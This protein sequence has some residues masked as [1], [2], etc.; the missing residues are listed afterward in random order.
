MPT[1][2]AEILNE[3]AEGVEEEEEE[4]AAVVVLGEEEE[5]VEETGEVTP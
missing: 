1:L 2:S 5:E 3:L 4:E